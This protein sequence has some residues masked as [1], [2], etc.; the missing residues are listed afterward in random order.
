MTSSCQ[1]VNPT[2]YKYIHFSVANDAGKIFQFRVNLPWAYVGWFINDEEGKRICSYINTRATK[3]KSDIVAAKTEIVQECAT[4][5][6]N[7]PIYDAS[8]TKGANLAVE[9]QKQ[10]AN[11]LALKNTLATI[12]KSFNVAQKEN[13]ELTNKKKESENKLKDMDATLMSQNSQIAS[14]QDKLKTMGDQKISNVESSAKFKKDAEGAKVQF[15]KE[16]VV[17]DKEAH[18]RTT[19]IQH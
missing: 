3:T 19:D 7:K 5:C 4:Y 17:L 16:A 11:I 6:A 13:D 12:E 14:I 1:Y 15:D 9:K 10:E 2:G 8:T 18:E